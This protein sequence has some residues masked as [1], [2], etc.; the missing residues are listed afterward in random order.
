MSVFDLYAYYKIKTDMKFGLMTR[1]GTLI[2]LY[3][4]NVEYIHTV[5]GSWFV[6]SKYGLQQNIRGVKSA[7]L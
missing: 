6:A 5:N 2:F 1:D 7:Q 3:C 4:Y